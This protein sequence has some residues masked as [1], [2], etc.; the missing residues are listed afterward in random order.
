MTARSQSRP[1]WKRTNPKKKSTA[2]SPKQKSEAK[3]RAR[4][5]GRNYPNLVDNMAMARK[6]KT[7]NTRKRGGRSPR[8]QRGGE[9]EGRTREA[10]QPHR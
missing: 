1:P 6:R 5:A 9:H 2:L 7:R 3:A 4:A 8:S 10:V